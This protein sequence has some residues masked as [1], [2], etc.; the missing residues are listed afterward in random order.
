MTAA[1]ISLQETLQRLARQKSSRLLGQQLDKRISEREKE[2]RKEEE[3][4]SKAISDISR[5]C[6]M[7]MRVDLTPEQIEVYCRNNMNA[8]AYEEGRRLFPKQVQALFEYEYLDGV[9]GGLVVG[10]GKTLIGFGIA[11]IAYS[12]G[13]RK[14]MMLF[15]PPLLEQMSAKGLKEARQMLGVRFPVHVLGGKTAKIRKAMVDSDRPG[16][17]L[18][19]YSLLSA[20][21]AES[22]LEGIRPQLVIADESH[23]LNNRNSARTR[24]LMKCVHYLKSEMVL[25]S[26]TLLSKAPIEHHHLI[27]QAL[28]DYCPLPHSVGLAKE[29]S[30][31]IDAK[32][33]SIF[34]AADSDLSGRMNATSVMTPFVDW[35]NRHGYTRY[36]TNLEGFRKSYQLRFR[37]TPGVVISDGEFLGTSLTIRNLAPKEEEANCLKKY[38][39][40]FAKLQ[41]MIKD[42]EEA[43]ITPDG[44]ELSHAMLSWSWLTQLASGTFISHKWPTK[45]S[46]MKKRR[47]SE[48]R[49]LE[50]LDLSRKHLEAQNEYNKEL[51]QYL[52]Y[53]KLD[54]GKDTP[55]LIAKEL[56]NPDN[57]LPIRL[58]VA[59]RKYQNANFAEIIQKEDEQVRVC[60]FKIDAAVDW[61]EKELPKGYGAV[62][63]YI[64]QD[65][66]LWAYEKLQEAGFDV[67]HCPATAR[68]SK[69]VRD[70][71][72]KNKIL[73]A[74]VGAH[75]EGK[76]LQ[77]L[78]Y[79]YFIEFPRPAQWAEQVLGRL[80]RTG[81]QADELNAD[82]YFV[83]AFEKMN[84][85]ACL[86]DSLFIHQTT[87]SK[88]KLIYCNYDPMPEVFP[89][90]VMRERGLNTKILK[91]KDQKMFKDKFG[92]LDNTFN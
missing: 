19:P 62:I 29:V 70:E 13:L 4:Q 28:K 2:E 25:L 8:Q 42:I 20:K 89:P 71:A 88:Q 74:S 83:F 68:G 11:N 43:M 59:W 53:G 41:M 64:H 12:K 33:G 92:V 22:I 1:S 73:V 27:R 18:V 60:S 79:Q 48:D 50:L 77:H 86:N 26:G 84:F 56:N 21:D 57:Q 72:N 75:R 51:R 81:Q 87:G 10:G 54:S 16:V 38:G 55:A 63:W 34:V 9:V 80:H 47:V 40:S 30:D 52:L 39:E 91:P 66:G 61:C 14:I 3:T 17:Y 36:Y 32:S 49:A 78:Q 67:I 58:N 90:D 23:R 5:I 44:D 65:V 37:T 6:A 24:R 46:V 35:A 31:F 69:E 76:N 15:P 45:E 7:P 85:A 82:M